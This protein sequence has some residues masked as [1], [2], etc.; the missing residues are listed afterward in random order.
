MEYFWTQYSDLPA[1]IG[2]GR[3]STEHWME[4]LVIGILIIVLL[5]IV[6]RCSERTQQFILRAVPV[7]M[8]FLECFK[9]LF[10]LQAGHFSVGYL[11]LHLCSLGV[12]VFLL[13]A[14]S[15]RRREMWAEIAFCLILP[16]SVVA[17]LLPDWAHLYPVW[18][19]MNL[20]GLT[21]HGLLVFYPLLL[22]LRGDV[23]PEIRHMRWSI[24]FLCCVTPPIYLFDRI[25]HTNY[26]FVNW[27]A[28]GTPLEWL[29]DR[30]GNPGYL[31]GYAVCILLVLTGYYG[32]LFVLNKIHARP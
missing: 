25:F 17:L 14:F 30:M 28:P 11:P 10:L 27:P 21:W 24:L 9:D 20:Y 23:H 6:L 31:L 7:L 26:L 13:F 32:L 16:G 12:F 19:F 18:N 22:Y 5:R 8:V 29:A 2:Y 1:G 15:S 4:L 3:F